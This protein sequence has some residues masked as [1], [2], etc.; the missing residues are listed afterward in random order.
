MEPVLER[1]KPGVKIFYTWYKQLN[2]NAA[3]CML[4]KNYEVI[5]WHWK[6]LASITDI[7]IAKS[8]DIT[9]SI[10]IAKSILLA[11]KLHN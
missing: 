5:F 4:L 7:S 11:L 8:I 1:K 6:I 2:T 3:S 9:K 10:S